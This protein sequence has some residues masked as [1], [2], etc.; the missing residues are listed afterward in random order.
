MSNN[1]IIVELNGLLLEE[2]VDYYWRPG[3]LVLKSPKPLPPP[4]SF[5]EKI[6]HFLLL[7]WRELGRPRYPYP[8]LVVVENW[9]MHARDVYLYGTQDF[10]DHVAYEEDF[11][12]SVHRES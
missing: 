6:K 3:K 5:W 2:G 9:S 10:D 1:K 4:L 11:E 7:E 8:D 12:P